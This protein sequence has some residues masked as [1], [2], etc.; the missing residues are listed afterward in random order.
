[1]AIDPFGTTTTSTT[2]TSASS[3]MSQ[4]SEDYESFITLLTAQIENQ[5][6]LEPMDSTTF[7]S[8]LAQLSQVE[9]SVATNS[10]LEGIA[11]QLASMGA[12]TGLSLIGRSVVAATDEVTLESDGASAE[13]SYALASDAASVTMTITAEDGTVLRTYTG[14][15]TSSA[16]RQTVT[17]DG[18]DYE[19]LPLPAG[20]YTV[21]VEALDTDGNTI[22]SQTYAPAKVASMTYEDGLATLHLENG[23]TV[24]AGA[25]EEIL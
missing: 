2:T 13:L 1:M 14:L 24:L 6:P 9:Q 17:W 7:I 5:N 15:E 19:G 3:S 10:N 21:S 18:M 4:L 25:V 23:D 12:I 8:Q 11:S 16:E 20:S 22:A